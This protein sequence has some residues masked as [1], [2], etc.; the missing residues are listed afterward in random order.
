MTIRLDEN[1][2]QEVVKRF[3]NKII[4]LIESEAKQ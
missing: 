2:N 4:L 1:G 3:L